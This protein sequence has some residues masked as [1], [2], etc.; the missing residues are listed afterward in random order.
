MINQSKIEKFLE[1]LTA[2]S[3]KHGIKINPS[4]CGSLLFEM[5]EEENYQYKCDII[6]GV[7]GDVYF[8]CGQAME[9]AHNQRDEV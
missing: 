6:N 9:R 5:Q 1:E 7:M 4:E 3:I 2:V 8:L